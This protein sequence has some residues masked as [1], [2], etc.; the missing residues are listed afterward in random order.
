[1]KSVHF[2]KPP[3]L[4]LSS[5][6]I[7][8]LLVIMLTACNSTVATYSSSQP[9][10]GSTAKATTTVSPS[11]SLDAGAG[12]INVNV[13]VGNLF[14]QSDYGFQCPSA[15][16]DPPGDANQDHLVL[17]SDR[18][19]YSTAEIAQMSAYLAEAN[20]FQNMPTNTP[21]TLQW[22]LGGQTTLLPGT[23][24]GFAT[25]PDE[26]CDTELT[27]TN[28]GNAPIQISSVGVQLQA[29]PQQNTYQYHLIDVC[30]FIASA[31]VYPG[32]GGGGSCSVYYA[33][34]HLGLG[35]QHDI[36]SAVPTGYTGCSGPTLDPGT[37]IYL[38]MEFSPAEN[39]QQNL[40]YSVV[41]VFTV[42]TT[43]GNQTVAV[44]QLGK[45]LAFASA[46]QF[47]CYELQGTTFT[48]EQA[49]VFTL[50]P[51]PNPPAG[52]EHWCL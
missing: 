52:K 28:T 23:P 4:P 14:I 49:P 12:N 31:C 15:S 2:R 18:T 1:M 45:T 38:D 32:S 6:V 46:S 16:L 42:N 48:L 47:S 50:F 5:A 25:V 20:V 27:L 33:P 22:V 7:S 40:I 51:G 37:Q 41:P 24:P 11:T 44:P 26:N 39:I 17:A 13:H 34:I 8:F 35:K 9:H 43:Q 29:P 21:A 36:F 10:P 19:T 30:S 3:K